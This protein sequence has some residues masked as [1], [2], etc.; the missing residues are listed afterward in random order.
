[1][2]R[3]LV[4]PVLT[5][6]PGVVRGALWTVAASLCII[7]FTSI[8]KHLAQD[9]PL[10]VI[11]FLRC[12][13]GILFLVPWLMRTGA[14]GLKTRRPV[15]MAARGVNTMI[16]LYCVF[17]ALSLM[18]IADVVAIMFSKPLF[19]SL[20]A[21]LILGEVMYVQ[22]WTALVVGTIGMLIIIRPG[23]NELNVGV[24]FALAAMSCGS[25]TTI[26]V[27]ILTRTEAPDTIVAW[28]I[29]VMLAVSFVPAL[30]VWQTPNLTQALWL[31]ALGGLATGFQRCLTRSYAAADATVVM[32]FEFTR[33]I[34]AAIIGYAVFGELSDILTWT[35]GTVIFAAAMFLVHRE[36][37]AARAKTSG[38]GGA[39]PGGAGPD[40]A[41]PGG[42][43]RA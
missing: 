27:K 19:A 16:G 37:A 23:F 11:V 35:G 3:V 10:W 34:F 5:D 14:G 1:M 38:P 31:V 20:A 42:E 43:N 24:L 28:S 17:A 7:G 18:P 22:R 15:L 13:F 8:A 25:F 21:V 30:M 33:L 2:R 40:E 36:A 9:L 32:P 39:A 12:L 26:T 6:L 29:L 41:G 4:P